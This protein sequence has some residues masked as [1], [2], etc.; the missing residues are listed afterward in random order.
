MEVGRKVIIVDN[1]KELRDSGEN[2]IVFDMLEYAGKEAVITRINM[3]NTFE[4]DI[5]NRV[6][7][8]YPNMIN[9]VE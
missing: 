5:D 8:W 2:D 4:L 7:G 3:D 9:K 6:W 1:L